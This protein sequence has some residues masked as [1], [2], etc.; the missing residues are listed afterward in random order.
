MK[1]LRSSEDLDSYGDKG[2]GKDWGRR[3]EDSAIHRSSSHRNFHYKSESGRKGVSSSSS[4]RY[5]RVED[6]REGPRTVR[7][8]SDYDADGYDRRKSYDRYK[9]GNDRVVMN[10]SSPRSSYGGNRIHRSESFS[11]PR[12]D[13]PKGFRSERDKS[14]REGSVS[15]WRRF[16]GGKD[17]DEGTRSGSESVKINNTVSADASKV[18][19]PLHLIEEKSPARSKESGSEQTKVLRSERD[20]SRRE[21]SASSWRRFGGTKDS[22][23][24]IKS[25][26]ELV[27]VNDTVDISKVKSPRHL[28]EAKSPAWSKESGSEQSKSAECK[29]SDDFPL[30]S[31]PSR[32]VECKK[33]E[34]TSRSSDMEE[35][36]L[37]PDPHPVSVSDPLSQEQAS[38]GVE[39]ET[40]CKL[41]EDRES[42]PN[43]EDMDPK[44][45]EK[46]EGGPS[47]KPQD[48]RK[49]LNDVQN[50]IT[51]SSKGIADSKKETLSSANSGDGKDDEHARET[52]NCEKRSDDMI[53]GM[54]SNDTVAV[55]VSAS[56][57]ECADVE[58]K[59]KDI[60]LTITVEESVENCAPLVSISAPAAEE[61]TKN[62]KDK[63]KSVAI[64]TSIS[65]PILT[66]AVK[67]EQ[68][69]MT[70]QD[71]CIG[72]SGRG[73]ELF[74]SNP[75]KKA[76]KVE[77][78]SCEKNDEK[79]TLDLS[80]SLPNVLLPIGSNNQVQLPGSPSRARSSQSYR[81]TFLTNSD[82]FTTSFSGSQNFT[83]NPSCSL[84]HDSF[85]NC[86]QS[87]K[88][89]PLFQGVNWQALASNENK[90]KEVPL[91]EKSISGNGSYQKS[92]APER[93]ARSH[94][95]VQQLRVI[96]GSSNMPI[97]MERQL[98]FNKHLSGAQSWHSNDVRSPSAS[99]GSHDTRSEYTKD[100]NQLIKEK[101]GGSSFR[102]NRLDGKDLLSAGA[103]FAESLIPMIVSEPL[104]LMARRF[105]EMT[106]H[107]VEYVKESVRDIVLNPGKQW[108]LSAL[109]KAL[110]SKTDITL[111][112]LLMSHRVQLEIL[113]SLKTG[114]QEFLQ[115]IFEI[116]SSDL[117]EIFLSLRCRNLS[118]RSLLP[119][120]ECDCKIC[121][122]KNGFCSACMCLVCS[123]FDLASNTCSWVGCDMCLH[124]CH[125]DCGLQKSYIRNGPSAS[126]AEGLEMQF[127]C[128]AC[129][130]PSEMFGF[131]KEVFQNCAKQWTSEALSKELEY[132]GRIFSASEDVRGRRLHEFAVEMLAR[133]RN[134]TDLNKV[135]S[136]IMDFLADAE[137]YRSGGNAPSINRR[138]FST[139]HNDKSNGIAGSSRGGAEWLDSMRAEK[140][141]QL[142]KSASSFPS[143]DFNQNDNILMK[144]QDMQIIGRK[145]PVFDELESIV[146]IKH[147]EAK[148]FQG[149]AEEARREADALKHIAVQKNER[150]DEEYRNRI[151]KLRLIEAEEIRKQKL[152]ELQAVERGYQ[153]YFS[154][155]MRMET[156]IKDLLLKMEATRRNLT[157]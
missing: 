35:G 23:E 94:D 25:G 18:K 51:P 11:V 96:E 139:G 150:I 16:G 153:E 69:G 106:E 34:S 134:K 41:L 21:G 91:L 121:V 64:S 36:E 66:D 138:D 42:A 5:D 100:K 149:R 145:E 79:L 108:Q 54:S 80:L 77:Q 81:S 60:A 133:M 44:E 30:E 59:T 38:V 19:S 142:E 56:G 129:N 3:D 135:R 105:T 117:A 118:C 17:G 8:C 112:M 122:Q 26:S 157:M 73:F 68:R 2:G 126:R 144:Q 146:R 4:S 140:A 9:D 37:E 98:S 46:E 125:A 99:A 127:H 143:F 141:P 28:R 89:R 85:D 52:S 70:Y 67:T 15:S 148:M 132:V 116:S 6:D 58:A 62:I 115:Q 92:Q 86:E 102:I 33:I 65:T 114:L 12:R 88:S 45:E 76:E 53:V 87:V 57:A 103:D 82:G 93:N 83:H 156:D 1:R 24:V 124:W 113:V 22:D 39:G 31:E 84:T 97:Q 40:G 155:K 110:R 29:K 154:M 101:H 151:A 131:V 107:Q 72:P 71:T 27:K 90:A 47:E 32:S 128:V 13:F 61:I 75:V 111:Q 20:K 43:K 50:D 10:S 152:E 78:L 136:C 14:R 104:H 137:S 63:D 119:V 95:V 120:D 55:K 7:K 109:Q 147:A 48:G 130:H 74:T 49:E 123:K